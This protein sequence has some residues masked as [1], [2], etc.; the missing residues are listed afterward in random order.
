MNL[1]VYIFHIFYFYFFYI[2]GIILIQHTGGV[3]MS[4]SM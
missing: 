2:Y 3:V 1:A 4:G